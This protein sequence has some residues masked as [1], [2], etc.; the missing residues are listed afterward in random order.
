MSPAEFRPTTIAVCASCGDV[1]G[2]P[3]SQANCPGSQLADVLVR[4]LADAGLP[5]SVAR[6]PCMAVCDQP[7]TVAFQGGGVW[8]YVIG[9]VDPA[10]D[11]ED[12]ISVA[13]AI[14]RSEHG[15]PQLADR[16]PFFQR[17]V[18]C[19]LPPL[20]PAVSS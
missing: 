9:G 8:S 5:L 20:S 2:S 1:L 3:Q 6:V 15:V 16:P 11:V 18:L 12:L 10:S 17:G 19:R 7:V 4:R 13:M 14:A